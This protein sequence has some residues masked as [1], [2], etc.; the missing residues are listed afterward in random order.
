MTTNIC[1]HAFNVILH[2]LS[3][4]KGLLRR[5][6][7]S[8]LFPELILHSTIFCELFSSPTLESS[9]SRADKGR[10]SPTQSTV[11]GKGIEGFVDVQ[12]CKSVSEVLAPV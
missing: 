7:L 12:Y 11:S 2:F 5:C 1:L 10:K 6:T 9:S 3:L 8:A 4:V